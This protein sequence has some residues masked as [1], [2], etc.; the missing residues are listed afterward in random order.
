[1]WTPG[2]WKRHSLFENNGKVSL[3]RSLRRISFTGFL[4][5]CPTG[6]RRRIPWR[7]NMRQ[8]QTVGKPEFGN[9][10]EAGFALAGRKS[11]A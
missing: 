5:L 6:L 4:L 2:R 8:G 3:R 11:V 1:M 9:P 7:G 10:V